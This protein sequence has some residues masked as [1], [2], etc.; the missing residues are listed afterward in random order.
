M[1]TACELLP[2]DHVVLQHSSTSI[3]PK[4]HRYA[5]L[6]TSTAGQ[7]FVLVLVKCLCMN[8]EKKKAQSRCSITL[9]L[10]IKRLALKISHSSWALWPHA[11]SWLGQNLIQYVMAS[12]NQGW[13]ISFFIHFYLNSIHHQFSCTNCSC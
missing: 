12:L 7:L 1:C 2:R 5:P 10:T 3:P 11:G 13:K 4:G 8:S 9:F 6:H